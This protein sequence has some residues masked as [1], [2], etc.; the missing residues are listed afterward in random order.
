MS[1]SD[2]FFGVA[3]GALVVGA[4]LAV[5]KVLDDPAAC[6]RIRA[7]AEKTCRAVGEK[8]KEGCDILGEKINAGY[9]AAKEKANT[10]KETVRQKASE[11]YA[12]VCDKVGD[13]YAIVREKAEEAGAGIRS[14]VDESVAARK[15]KKKIS[16]IRRA[17][18]PTEEYFREEM[19][20]IKKEAR[21]KTEENVGDDA[22]PAADNDTE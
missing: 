6:Q 8:V 12:T 7:G 17:A 1:K 10:A 16:D 5:Q 2:T 22:E 11:G 14:A 9:A 20:E 21:T 4:T 3:L 18:E 19:E 15:I 13:G